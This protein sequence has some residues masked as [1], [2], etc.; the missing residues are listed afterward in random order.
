MRNARTLIAVLLAPLVIVAC[1]GGDAIE[2]PED[3]VTAWVA[4]LGSGNESRLAGLHAAETT[5]H[6]AAGGEVMGGEAVA[7][8]LLTGTGA[9]TEVA[10]SFITAA[11]SSVL[12]EVLLERGE[13]PDSAN[14]AAYVFHFAGTTIRHIYE[15]VPYETGGQ[16]VS[17]AMVALWQE[18]GETRLS[19]LGDAGIA[20]LRESQKYIQQNDRAS[21]VKLFG[22]DQV[23]V[24]APAAVSPN[25]LAELLFAHPHGVQLA[26]LAGSGDR[27]FMQFSLRH[28]HAGGGAGAGELRNLLFVFFAPGRVATSTASGLPIRGFTLYHA[29]ESAAMD[30]DAIRAALGR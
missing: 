4:A 16:V 20:A 23:I 10:S 27:A 13:A 1:G 9:V 11:R 25:D 3:A 24:G 15:Y 29:S 28:D 19:G 8:L 21:W 17:D 12:L 18:L 7:D 6:S 30:A 5:F 22:D 14:L 2:S 26:H